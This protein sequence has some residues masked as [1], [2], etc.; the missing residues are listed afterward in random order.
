MVAD[1]DHPTREWDAA[2]EAREGEGVLTERM[3]GR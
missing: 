1:D 2:K 3:R